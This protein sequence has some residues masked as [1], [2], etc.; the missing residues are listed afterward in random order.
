MQEPEGA[1]PLDPDEAAGLKLDSIQSRADLDRVEQANIIDGLRWLRGRRN[2]DVLSEAFLLELHRQLFGQV[3]H[4][5]G[6]FRRTEKNI[7]VDPFMISMRLRDLLD[8]CR[9]WIDHETWPPKELALRFH[10][11]LVSVHLF[12]NGNGRH[13][14]IAADAVSRFL[15]DDAPIDW[16]DVV[17]LQHAGRHRSRYIRALQAA[18][19]HN[20][21]PLLNLYG[22]D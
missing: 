4:W 21:A 11:R 7:G 5:A 10:H 19:G 18:D 13:A 17:E 14:R 22:A 1:T 6:R 9:Y 3:W 12:A 8:D 15:L 2:P 16:I 20:Y